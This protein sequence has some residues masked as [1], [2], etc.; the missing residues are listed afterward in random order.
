MTTKT[1]T[2]EEITAN[3]E[4]GIM[5]SL[6]LAAKNRNDAQTARFHSATAWGKW[7]AWHT[8]TQGWQAPEDTQRMAALVD[9]KVY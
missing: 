8:L 4:K 1:W 6:K 2:Y 9:E 3:A 7:F 5:H